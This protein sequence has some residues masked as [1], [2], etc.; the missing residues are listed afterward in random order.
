MLVN[1]EEATPSATVE[2][3]PTLE[4]TIEATPSATPT[5]TLIISNF[6]EVNKEYI[7]D[8]GKVKIIFKKIETS[9]TLDVKK[10]DYKGKPAYDINSTMTNGSFSY[11]LYFLRPDASKKQIKYSE[12]G[13][14]L[15][16]LESIDDGDYI[17]VKNLDHFTIFVVVD[18]DPVN[19]DCSNAAFTVFIG[20][21]CFNTIQAAVD[22]ATSSAVISIKNGTY[23]ENVI[24][25]KSGISLIGESRDGVIIK[26]PVAGSNSVGIT[27]QE[28]G[29]LIKSLTVR[30]FADGVSLSDVD[31]FTLDGSLISDNS[32][33]IPSGIHILDSKNI[34]IKNNEFK[35]NS[36]AIDL[37]ELAEGTT[38]NIFLTNNTFEG[39]VTNLVNNIQ[40]DILDATSN[41]WGSPDIDVI[42]NSIVHSCDT[43]RYLHGV[44]NI[45][46]LSSDFGSVKYLNISSPTFTSPV[47]DSLTNQSS[48]I[49]TWNNVPGANVSYVVE[50]TNPAS[51][52]TLDSSTFNMNVD[53]I[54]KWRIKATAGSQD[55]GYGDY[56]EVTYDAT[57]PTDPGVPSTLSPTR[58]LVQSWFWTASTDSLSGL[59]DYSWFATGGSSGTVTSNSLTTFLTQG[60]WNFN[61]IA[62]DMAGNKSSTASGSLIV[63]RS[64][65]G[66]SANNNS[67]AWYSINPDI[68]LS[69]VDVGD[70]LVYISK[71]NWDSAANETE[72]TDFTNGQIINIPSGGEHVLYLYA[73][74]YASNSSTW[75]G[76]YK[77]DT[78]NPVVSSSNTSLSWVNS[79]ASIVVSATDATPGSSLSF[80][81][82]AWN[83]PASSGTLTSDGANLLSS[84]VE[85]DQVLNLYAEDV[86]GRSA[87]SSG[88][89]RFDKTSPT[90]VWAVPTENSTISGTTDLS[91]NTDDNVSGVASI[92]FKYAPEGSTEFTVITGSVW[93]TTQ[94]SLGKYTLRATIVDK[95]GNMANVDE[96]VFIAAVITSFKHR[97]IS[98]TEILIEWTTDR[99]TDGRVV[100]DRTSHFLVS[101]Y[102]NSTGTVNSAPN[103]STSH[104]VVIGGLAP[105]T[106]YHYRA[107]S[108]GTP[109]VISF[110]ESDRT[111]SEAVPGGVSDGRSTYVPSSSLVIVP[112]P[113]VQQDQVAGVET[114]I[115]EITP[116]PISTPQVEGI[117]TDLP[118]PSDF[119]WWFLLIPAVFLSAFLLWL[120]RRTRN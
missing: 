112:T 67:S 92:V 16:K 5:P 32:Y 49:P 102:P 63:D 97:V 120:A 71:Y 30:E 80:V 87:T 116:T 69:V 108:A 8:D 2:V 21:K 46:D 117:S 101:E 81:K 38:E 107:V 82:Y 59:K 85:G 36:V 17:A 99:P 28:N 74:D 42:E 12:N 31:G 1:A 65:P 95:A 90:G 25:N 83:L 24:L 56:C 41:N 60:T 4:P 52:S 3:L 9:G 11:D 48:I 77:L 91:I 114:E 54:W 39:N 10:I 100:Y 96:N 53:G 7:F 27:V 23:L 55:S 109:V 14:Q 15:N 47:C 105:G 6:V 88:Q 58:A 29:I 19:E 44:C 18:P 57:A 103:Y 86:S 113:T 43:D 68:T 75:S 72:G 37:S 70:S 78:Q 62:N 50:R 64:S 104:S 35:N 22:A 20:D 13:E 111:S 51:I 76:T 115:I 45:E 98:T 94:L 89:Y 61:I 118:T 79:V 93:D 34:D 40:K 84:L 106:Y 73:V 119:N 66:L 26:N 110:E 33:S